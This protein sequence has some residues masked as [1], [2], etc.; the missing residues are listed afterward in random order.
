DASHYQSAA[1]WRL[2]DR[3]ALAPRTTSH[4][5]GA[6]RLA[7][8]GGHPEATAS[9]DRHRTRRPAPRRPRPRVQRGTLTMAT[10]RYSVTPP[11]AVA[12]QP[13]A[14]AACCQTVARENRE[15]WR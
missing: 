13:A 6:G 8:G 14:R 12:A 4:R 7:G 1:H 10:Q 3:A 9:R 15:A 11:P 5:G 2:R